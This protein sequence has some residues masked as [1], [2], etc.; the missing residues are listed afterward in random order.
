MIGFED[1]EDSILF[2]VGTKND[3]IK[4]IP[5]VVEFYQ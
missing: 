4:Y 1:V 2:H 3:G 5:T